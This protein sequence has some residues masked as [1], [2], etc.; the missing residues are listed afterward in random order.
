MPSWFSE[1]PSRAS[2]R[3]RVESPA[4][5]NSRRRHRVAASPSRCR[6]SGRGPLGRPWNLSSLARMGPSQGAA[7]ATRRARRRQRGTC[8]DGPHCPRGGR[9]T[10]RTRPAHSGRFC[11]E[12]SVENESAPHRG[13]RRGGHTWCLI[14]ILKGGPGRTSDAAPLRPGRPASGVGGY[15]LLLG[16]TSSFTALR[17]PVCRAIAKSAPTPTG[18]RRSCA[19]CPHGT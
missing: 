12:R 15:L 9:C 17:G 11:L 14:S 2:S 13:A 19:S 5:G 3:S 8:G 7:H 1:P 4:R 18:R 10:P 16:V 6:A